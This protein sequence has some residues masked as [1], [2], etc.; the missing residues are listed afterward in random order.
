MSPG[1]RRLKAV[2]HYSYRRVFLWTK[3][4]HVK[5]VFPS[6]MM[7]AVTLG[8]EEFQ[9]VDWA[10]GKVA[11]Y[12]DFNNKC[13]LLHRF[14]YKSQVNNYLHFSSSLHILIRY[15]YCNKKSQ[16]QNINIFIYFVS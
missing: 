1:H 13:R 15:T 6:S 8:A 16:K 2:T 7:E 14:T 9:T 4:R 5:A 12:T 10:V 11:G 3:L